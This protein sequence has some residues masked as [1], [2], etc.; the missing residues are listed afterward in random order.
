MARFSERHGYRPPPVELDERE[1]PA[2]L[3]NGLWDVF[4]EVYLKRIEVSD[5]AGYNRWTDPGFKLMCNRVWFEFLRESVD[6]IPA[7]PEAAL[8]Q[9]RTRFYNLEFPDLYDFVEFV[10]DTPGANGTFGDASSRYRELC[11]LVFERE[12]CVF[13]FAG[14][15]LVRI[16]NPEEV[17]EIEIA[18]ERHHSKAVREHISIAIRHYSNRSDPDYRNSI[19]ESISAVEAAINFALG[20]KSAGLDGPLKVLS[21]Q[22]GLHPALSAGFLKLYGYTSDSQG[23]RHALMDVPKLKQGDA[24]YMLVACSAFANYIL[25]L[26]SEHGE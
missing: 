16:S 7:Y 19:N 26:S 1:I 21:Q 2:S 8:G 4:R 18:V 25:L 5:P 9:L 3:R 17:Q 6:S 11:N 10:A 13:R 14:K 23:I 20:S 15:D 12:L 22:Y 24:R